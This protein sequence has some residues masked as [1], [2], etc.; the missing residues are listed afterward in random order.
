MKCE[1]AYIYLMI[2]AA[3]EDGVI[4]DIE[5]DRIN[6]VVRNNTKIYQDFSDIN[7]D[8][9][10]K[11]LISNDDNFVPEIIES[12]DPLELEIALSFVCSIISIDC[13]I[14]KKEIDFIN[15]LGKE[16]SRENFEK[17]IYPFF[18]MHGIPQPTAPEDDEVLT[19]L[20]I[21][22]TDREQ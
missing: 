1:K 20:R 16:I 13:K 8:D 4:D 11:N 14:T 7:L 21:I 2:V 15:R 3:S 9:Y 18:L 5:K 12:L 22:D 6:Y 10:S 19:K 17:I